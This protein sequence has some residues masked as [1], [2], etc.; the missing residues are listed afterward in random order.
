MAAYSLPHLPQPPVI[1]DL[2]VFLV[3]VQPVVHDL[4]FLVCIVPSVG[5]VRRRHRVVLR[6]C[7]HM[8]ERRFSREGEHTAL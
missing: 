1:S 3:A 4:S 7:L 5:H 2:C 6:G 8:D